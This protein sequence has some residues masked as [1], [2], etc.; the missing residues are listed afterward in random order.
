MKGGVARYLSDLVRA[1]KGAMKVIVP[2][3]HGDPGEPVERRAFF[4]SGL[5]RWW[6][7]VR[8][9]RELGQGK[10]T[11]VFISHVLP[12][13]TAAWIASWL[14]GAPYILL[15]HGLDLHLAQRTALK[16]WLTKRIVGRAQAICVNS[17]FVAE[18][19]KLLFPGTV[20]VLLTPGYE[21]HVL[22]ARAEARA[23]LGLSPDEVIL[24]NV[25]RLIPRKG[26][27][28]LIEILPELPS[29]VRAVSIGDGQ[30]K[31]RLESLAAHQKARITF[32]GATDD[33]TRDEWYA[34]ADVFVFPVRTDGDDVEGY[35]IV[36]LE[37]S[38]AGLPVI[39][40]MNGGAPETVIQGET[41]LIVNAEE[42]KELLAAIKQLVDDP[43]LRVRM[44]E[45]GR[46]R[47]L[48][49]GS[50][51]ERWNKLSHLS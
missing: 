27:D 17:Q 37:A 29:H 2:I 28:R 43:A 50:W 48:K 41:G 10:K 31:A 13:G 51:S 7:L 34:A 8:L 25:T 38:A 16:R 32:L 30:D 33:A 4:G 22:P 11:R 23:R 3:E 39:V 35:G 6:P 14:G 1:S 44:G 21:P 26:L 18:E 5:V 36:C 49:E 42:Q 19:C 12:I 15:F 47:V 40:G 46:A 24:L 45:R 20:P 9:M